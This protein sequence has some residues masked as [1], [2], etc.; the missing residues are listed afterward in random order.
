MDLVKCLNS[1]IA[2][3]NLFGLIENLTSCLRIPELA[4]SAELAAYQASLNSLVQENRDSMGLLAAV[5]T[6][7]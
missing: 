7:E 6:G 2:V 1:A 4:A 5:F 3:D